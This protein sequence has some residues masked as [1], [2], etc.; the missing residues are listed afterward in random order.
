M[1]VDLE[2]DAAYGDLDVALLDAAGNIVARD[3][4][5]TS[6]GCVAAQI[7]SGRYYIGVRGAGGDVNRYRLSVRADSTPP[8]CAIN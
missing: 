4:T 2:Y 7:Q 6:N 1:R 8:N 3:G 5:R